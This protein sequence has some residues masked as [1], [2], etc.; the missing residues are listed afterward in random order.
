MPTRDRT[1]RIN[2]V[3]S[4]RWW[5]ISVPSMPS[6]HS[7]C[8]R[9]EQVDEY[10]REAISLVQDCPLDE[11]GHLDVRVAAPDEVAPLIAHAEQAAAAA[12]DASVEVLQARR[13]AALALS[14]RGYPTRD[15]GALLGISHQRVSQLLADAS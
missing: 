12:R 3:R 11:V 7:P 1:I 14:E 13:A 10:A 9:L 15:I 4:G 8:R 2:V 6:V 5:A